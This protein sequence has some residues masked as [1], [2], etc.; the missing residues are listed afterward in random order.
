MSTNPPVVGPQN[1]RQNG[2]TGFGSL[3]LGSR[4][5]ALAAGYKGTAPGRDLL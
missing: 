2:R 1:S 4:M 3:T 5:K